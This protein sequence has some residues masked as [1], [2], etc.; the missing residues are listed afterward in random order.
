[1]MVTSSGDVIHLQDNDCNSLSLSRMELLEAIGLT[2]RDI[3]KL[4]GRA[5]SDF[6][7]VTTRFR[8]GMR[9]DLEDEY[10]LRDN[11]GDGEYEKLL[12]INHS[13]EYSWDEVPLRISIAPD[14]EVEV[15]KEVEIKRSDEEE[16]E[17]E[18]ELRKD[19]PA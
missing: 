10:E 6:E 3:D 16:A 13:V 18:A 1:M 9:G 2:R 15:T 4:Q 14:V 5:T 7:L 19:H 8:E 11:H 17:L 12:T